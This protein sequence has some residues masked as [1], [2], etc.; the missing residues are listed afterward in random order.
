M[1]SIPEFVDA[2]Y[3]R[4]KNAGEMLRIEAALSELDRKLVQANHEL[5]RHE[6]AIRSK[7]TGVTQKAL[8]SL[9]FSQVFGPLGGMLTTIN[10]IIESWNDLDIALNSSNPQEKKRCIA[11]IAC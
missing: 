1:K 6:M 4:Q 10:G 7:A 2:K 3:K 5:R 11:I 8:A 9:V